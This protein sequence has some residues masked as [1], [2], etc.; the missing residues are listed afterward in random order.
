M[1]ES[2]TLMPVLPLRDVVVHRDGIHDF[3]PHFRSFGFNK[4]SWFVEAHVGSYDFEVL[5]DS[6][7][8]HMNHPGRKERRNRNKHVKA[9]FL[10]YIESSYKSSW[11]DIKRL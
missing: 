11:T 2:R 8:V 4:V 6:F 5:P 7:V 3:Y 9:K 10:K 1:F